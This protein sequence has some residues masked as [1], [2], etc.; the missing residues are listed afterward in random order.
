MYVT[1]IVRGLYCSYHSFTVASERSQEYQV[2]LRLVR[3]RFWA[4]SPWRGGT[5]EEKGL[6]ACLGAGFL[7]QDC[8]SESWPSGGWGD[9]EWRDGCYQL[10]WESPE[11][12]PEEGTLR[13]HCLGDV[14]R[15]LPREVSALSGEHPEGLSGH[16]DLQMGM[17]R[18]LAQQFTGA[19]W[20]GKWGVCR[21][22]N[23]TYRKV[24]N[25]GIWQQEEELVMDQLERL[26]KN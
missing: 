7:V 22:K 12:E 4:G 19:L 18:S 25:S 11:E 14:D 17:W 15:P 21:E 6:S 23:T 9:S 13:A 1:K 5:W 24:Q 3:Q 8:D 16:G 20:D 10:K 26:K 2:G